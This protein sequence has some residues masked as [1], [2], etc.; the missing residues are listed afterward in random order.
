ML[1]FLLMQIV[2][3]T[4][5]VCDTHQEDPRLRFVSLGLKGGSFIKKTFY[6]FHVY[7]ITQNQAK[8]LKNEFQNR[9]GRCC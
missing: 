5:Q 3:Q 7:S 4:F 8:P 2:A 9:S 1:V 6:Q